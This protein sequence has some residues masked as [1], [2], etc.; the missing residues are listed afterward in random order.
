MNNSL[1]KYSSMAI[2][3]H[4]QYRNHK[5]V[6]GPCDDILDFMKTYFDGEII[7]LSHSIYK[8]NGSV[9]EIYQ[10][11]QLQLFKKNN[12][13]K[14]FPNVLRYMMDLIVT[15]IWFIPRKPVGLVVAADPLNFLYA[16][17]LKSL[18]KVDKIVYYSLD[19]AY[20]R[21]DN[22]V[23]NKI[24]H[25]L[26]LFAV[27]K[28]NLI[29]NACVKIREVRRMQGVHDREN[30]HLP[31]TPI[32]HGVGIKKEK[33]IDKFSLVNIFSN[34]KQVDFGIMFKVLS[35]LIEHFPEIT[36]KLI[37][38]GDF[39]KEVMSQIKDSRI[40]GHIKFMDISSHI[41][42]LEEISRCAIGLECNTQS[43]CWN[44]FREPIKIM[45]YIT[46]GLPIISKPGHALVDEIL[47]EKIGFI[48]RDEN[49]MFR[50]VA[51][52]LGNPNYYSQV[53]QRVLNLAKN[54]NKTRILY[55]SLSQLN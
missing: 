32:L 10:N 30:I 21:F 46:F 16:Y 12:F 22:F 28:S 6:H 52:L 51:S 1:Q 3:T 7:Y 42:A 34:H 41:E 29:W 36:L 24:Y 27:K 19:Y 20:R 53:R 55:N 39:A 8:G 17:V 11:D 35:R 26:D 23:L 14:D 44:E 31:N 15:F 43:L 33:E 13:S 47:K 2:F 5:P 48:V 49:E 37:G 50:A 54:Q 40:R 9:L 4:T 45:E 38:R 25:L 18:K